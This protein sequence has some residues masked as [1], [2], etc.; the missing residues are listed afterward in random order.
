MHRV[1]T[2]DAT[3][4]LRS[5]IVPLLWIAICAPGVAVAD[6]GLHVRIERVSAQ[7]S[8]TP[9]DYQ[10]YVNRGELYRLHEEFDAALADYAEAEERGPLEFQTTLDFLRGRLWYGAG[11]PDRAQPALDRFLAARPNHLGGRLVR[12]K[13]NVK[14]GH[15]E[16]ALRDFSTAIELQDRPS[17]DLY[18]DRAR[19][20]ASDRV[21]RPDESL[22]GIDE[23]ISQLGPL[24]TLIQFA[25]ELEARR[26]HF[27]AAI[28][29]IDTLPPS[30]NEQP[31]WLV[32]RGYLLQ[33][34][35]RAEEAHHVYDQAL[36]AIAKLPPARRRAKANMALESEVQQSIAKLAVED[37]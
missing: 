19:L 29:R 6:E 10:L 1:I 7:I 27:E 22:R 17:P 5:K 36:V 3:I 33:R 31:S 20:L 14:M 21:N 8:V 18:L 30:L 35:G 25:V 9:D 26:G 15:L 16:P 32:R 12:A 13:V 2:R 28:Q 4:R 23:A 24:V 11:R 37:F 34:A